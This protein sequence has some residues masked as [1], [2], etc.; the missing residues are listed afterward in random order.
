MGNEYEFYFGK[1]DEKG[2]LVESVI[3]TGYA[4]IVM[5]FLIFLLIY[6]CT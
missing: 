2:S 1:K 5:G 3:L 4:S 6:F